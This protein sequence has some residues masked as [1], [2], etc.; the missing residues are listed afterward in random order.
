MNIKFEVDSIQAEFDF[1]LGKLNRLKDGSKDFEDEYFIENYIPTSKDIEKFK[2]EYSHAKRMIESHNELL[3]KYLGE[4]KELN[5]KLS[6]INK[7]LW[8]KE[9]TDNKTTDQS[10]LLP[11]PNEQ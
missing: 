11:A 5:T 2:Y 4:I 6:I 3:E 10:D 7:T 8:D 1:I 9:K